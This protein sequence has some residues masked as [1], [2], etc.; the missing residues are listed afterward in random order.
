M[1]ANHEFPTPPA[2]PPKDTVLEL[3]DISFTINRRGE[4]V[5]LIHKASLRLPGSHF[6]AIVGPS[7]CGKTTLLKTIAGIQ[8]E[9]D[10]SIWWKG[11]NLATEG[12]LEPTEIGYVP[13]F[14]IAHDHLTVEESVEYAIQLRVATKSRQEVYD[15]ADSVIDQVGL[16]NVRENRVKVL[17]GG[18]KRRLGLALELVSN[19]VLLLCD[20]VTSG[21][22]PRSERDIVKLLHQLSRQQDRIVASVTHS[23]ANLEIYD[24]V[25]VVHE[26]N[27]VYHGPPRALAHYFSVEEA[28]D[29]YPQLARRPADEWRQSW[30]KHRSAY[31]DELPPSQVPDSKGEEESSSDEMIS[32]KTIQLFKEA[33]DSAKAEHSDKPRS[34]ADGNSLPA[35]KLPNIF[36]QF[37]ALTSRRW[38]IFLRDR[39]Q[40]FLQLAILFGFPILVVIFATEGIEPIKR[41]SETMN[42][43]IVDELQEQA[44]FLQAQL[45]TGSLVSGLIMFQVILLTLMASNNSAREIAGERLLFEKEKLA[46]LRPLAYLASKIWILA[47]IAAIQAVWMFVFV[48][49][50]C[51]IPGDPLYHSLLLIL[52]TL[53]MTFV[54]L[55]ISG[56]M[57][58]PEQSSL[59]SVYLVGFQLP[60]SGAV[61]AL[62]AA[63]ESFTRPF[64][65]AYWSWSGIVSTLDSG[66]FEAVRK[67]TDTTIEAAPTCILI[68]LIHMLVGLTLAYIGCKRNRWT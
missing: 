47:V 50:F 68:L 66:F 10:G 64:I 48:E 25:I 12:D 5:D 29:V 8:A 39:V 51:Q 56:L 55:G 49:S 52:V 20:E 28:E 45:K 65:S 60:L 7:G 67:T 46:G 59:L 15:L 11:R 31:Y 61:L 37:F 57:R 13:Q 26:G 38:K 63:V 3:H 30:L 1:P 6:V 35:V 22:D 17:S 23:L 14:S 53:A 24:S 36:S 44:G 43:N 41:L 9:S 32:P 4:E 18:Q 19:P 2:T 58:S 27:V 34:E 33:S 42:E 40:F 54:C 62:P 21:L 16:D